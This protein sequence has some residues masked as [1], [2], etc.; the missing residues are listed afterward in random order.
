MFDGASG[1]EGLRVKTEGGFGD[2]VNIG[3][4]I[5]F[6]VGEFP[7]W[8]VHDAVRALANEEARVSVD[9][10]G[11]ETPGRGRSAAGD[12]WEHVDELFA[13]GDTVGFE[14]TVRTARV[15]GSAN[16]HAEFHE[17]LVEVRAVIFRRSSRRK[18]ALN[19]AVQKCEPPYVG[20]YDFDIVPISPGLLLFAKVW[21]WF[22]FRA[23]RL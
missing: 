10:E 13:M 17:G 22:S 7:E 15:F 8:C 2:F 5:D 9:D 18:E 3:F 1:F 23:G 20:C 14:W 11:E 4:A 16:E 12:V 21:H 6:N 19:L